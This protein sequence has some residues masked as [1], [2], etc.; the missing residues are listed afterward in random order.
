MV[1]TEKMIKTIKHMQP[2]M[3][4]MEN[5]CAFERGD[6]DE[7]TS[8]AVETRPKM[9]DPLPH[10]GVAMETPSSSSCG[11]PPPPPPPPPRAA[12]FPPPPPKHPHDTRFRRERN[13]NRQSTAAKCADA[14][15]RNKRGSALCAWCAVHCPKKPET[16]PDDACTTHF[17]IKNRCT[18]PNM[19]CLNQ[20]PA[21]GNCTTMRCGA[22]CTDKNCPRHHGAMKVDRP[23]GIRRRGLRTNLGYKK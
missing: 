12:D 20:F 3:F 9:R 17:A 23:S 11:P 16:N 2:V 10:G 19:W 6:D 14:V 7:G 5:V 22:H 4:V 15:C 18:E 13:Y 1:N 21:D 8:E